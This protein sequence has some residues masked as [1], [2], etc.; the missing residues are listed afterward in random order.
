MKV[1]SYIYVIGVLRVVTLV[2]CTALYT[3]W[4]AMHVYGYLK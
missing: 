1:G 4:A 2:G 3:W